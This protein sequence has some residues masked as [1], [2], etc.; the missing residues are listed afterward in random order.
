MAPYYSSF[1]NNLYCLRLR[2]KHQQPLLY[3][4]T[5]L[6]HFT[7]SHCGSRT[8]LPTLKPDLTASAPRLSTSCLPSFTGLGVSP[9]YTTRSRVANGTFTQRPSRNRTWTSRFIRLLSIADI[10]T[11]CCCSLV[12]PALTVDWWLPA[13]WWCSF[14]P[15]PLQ[16]LHHYYKHLRP[17]MPHLYFRPRL[18]VTCAFSVFRTS[19]FLRSTH[20]PAPCSCH[21]NAGCRIASHRFAA[22]LFPELFGEPGF[23]IS[24]AL[25]TLLQRFTFVHLHGAHLPIFY[26]LFPTAHLPCLLNRAA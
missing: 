12:P 18:S 7:L 10:H 21:L 25:T 16:E 20:R 14:T 23:D 15:F 26:G 4:F 9:N 1:T 3:L 19:R 8:P 2:G 13:D 17:C 11:A 22:L 5:G 24:F 6:N